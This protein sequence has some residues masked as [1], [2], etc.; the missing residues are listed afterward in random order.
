MVIG[1]ARKVRAQTVERV[2]FNKLRFVVTKRSSGEFW[3]RAEIPFTTASP[4][5]FT[6]IQFSKRKEMDEM[7]T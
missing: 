5:R 3:T 4:A 1:A 7:G 6:E 2:P